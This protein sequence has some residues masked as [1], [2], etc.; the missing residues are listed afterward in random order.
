MKG[1]SWHDKRHDKPENQ[2]EFNGWTPGFRAGRLGAMPPGR[3]LEGCAERRR[4]AS[5]WATLPVYRPPRRTAWVQDRA[6]WGNAAGRGLAGCEAHWRAASCWATLPRLWTAADRLGSGQGG[7]GQRRRDGASRVA[8]SAAGPQ[9]AGRLC[10]V[11]GPPAGEPPQP[12]LDA[13]GGVCKV[14]CGGDSRRASGRA[15]PWGPGA[16]VQNGMSSSAKLLS[17]SPPPAGASGPAAGLC[18]GAGP[19]LAAALPGESPAPLR[20][21]NICISLA[22]TSVV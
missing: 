1:F 16:P 7:L 13:V 21:L 17:A 5:C 11:Y 15:T 3:G 4:A 22:T 8:R 19:A 9:V 12:R 20:L 14:I 10:R 2:P 18:A 6:T